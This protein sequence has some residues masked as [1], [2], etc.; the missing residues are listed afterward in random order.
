MTYKE[1][2]NKFKVNEGEEATYEKMIDSFIQYVNDRFEWDLDYVADSIEHDFLT[3]CK[4]RDGSG[5]TFLHYYDPDEIE[6]VVTPD[7]RVLD[8]DDE[9]I[10]E[11]TKYIY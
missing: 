2:L 8:N 7:G 1:L 4:T 3:D 10:R 6:L 11:Y 5:L 9:E